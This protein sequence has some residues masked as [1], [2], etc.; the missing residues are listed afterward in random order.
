MLIL[1][2]LALS[3]AKAVA[4]IALGALLAVVLFVIGLYTS[5]NIPTVLRWT[6]SAG[7]VVWYA[8]RTLSAPQAEVS[9][10]AAAYANIQFWSDAIFY[11]LAAIILFILGFVVTT[12]KAALKVAW[13][14][15]EKW[16]K[17]H[18]GKS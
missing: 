17:D 2:I 13:A 9:G 18:P 8:V 12:V 14:S 3:F 1:V 15:F 5:L 4:A 11:G 16:G 10:D 7:L 6:L